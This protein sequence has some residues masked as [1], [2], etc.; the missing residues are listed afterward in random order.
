M[1]KAQIYRRIQTLAASVKDYFIEEDPRE[2]ARRHMKNAS[3][4]L[5]RTIYQRMAL[6]HELNS[7][8][9]DDEARSWCHEN[10]KRLE[11]SEIAMSQ[12][13]AQLRDQY[14]KLALQDLFYKTLS[15]PN[16]DTFEEAHQAL[17]ELKASVEAEQTLH[18]RKLS[19]VAP[20]NV[21]ENISEVSESMPLEI[22]SPTLAPGNIPD[23]NPESNPENTP[24]SN[25]DSNS[26][27]TPESTPVS[28]PK[29]P[30]VP[31]VP[32]GK[33]LDNADA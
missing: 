20:G 11:Q 12:N 33:E 27:N 28:P 21:P 6:E 29:L 32:G 16:A 10:L 8:R 30:G 17:L 14:R 7:G 13:I 31:G 23:N 1:K 3:A 15:D 22:V 26:K 25:P 18:P 19:L 24:G 9:L 2:K 5:N 4:A